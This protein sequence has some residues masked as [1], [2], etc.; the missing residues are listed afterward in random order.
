MTKEQTS[1][2]IQMVEEY[3]KLEETSLIMVGIMTLTYVILATIVLVY[4]A[5]KFKKMKQMHEDYLH[6]LTDEQLKAIKENKKYNIWNEPNRS[7]LLYFWINCRSIYIN[8]VYKSYFA[9]K[10]Q[11][12]NKKEKQKW[13]YYHGLNTKI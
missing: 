6:T 7:K 4:W 1:Q 9:N 10:R 13:A 5:K 11:N 8:S 3:N 2:L 12:K